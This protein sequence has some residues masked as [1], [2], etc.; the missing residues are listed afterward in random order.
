MPLFIA[1]HDVDAATHQN[2]VDEL[3]P[4]GYRPVWLNVSGNFA[5][6]RYAAIWVADGGPGWWAVHN[7][8]ADTYQ[9]RFE[10]LTAKGY[11]PSV[12]SVTGPVENAVFAAI[13]E[14]R[15]VSAWFARHN[16]TFDPQESPDS[17]LHENKRAFDEGYLPRCLAVYGNAQNRRFA[18][19]WWKNVDAVEWGWWFSDADFYQ[20]LFDAELV[21]DMRP[22]NLA[23][24]DDHMLLSVFRGD[25][26]GPW[27]ARH[28]ITGQ[29]YQA[30]FDLR[31]AEGLRPI[32]VAAGGEADDAQYAA[33]FAGQD[34][35]IRREWHVTGE[36]S[37]GE[38]ELDAAMRSVM[39]SH[40]CVP[41]LL[42]WRGMEYCGP[43]AVTRGPNQA[44][45]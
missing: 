43:L 8:D 39:V 31:V 14:A 22:A 35:G 15:K 41:A 24:A 2:R 21:G 33:V 26:V 13:F 5:D 40:G 36:P 10:D 9:Q 20:R 38:D 32:I 44:T 45:R 3:G 29:E 27:A 18:G 1:Y 6:A 28:R 34:E 16:L 30:E 11:V 12:V 19:V 4:Q 7:I 23:V 37:R 25:R 42:Q 17:L